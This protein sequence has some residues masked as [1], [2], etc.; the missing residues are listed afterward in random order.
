MA[1][2]NDEKDIYLMGFA[3]QAAT[4]SYCKRRQ[5]GAIIARDGRPV[6]TG[7][8]G[9][10]SGL[11]NECEDENGETSEFTVHAEQNAIA[12]CA[13]FG[14]ASQGTTMYITLSP[15]AACAKLIA[16]CGIVRV[17]YKERYKDASGIVYL[18]R[19]GV[20]VDFLN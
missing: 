18:L 7:M 8:N 14:I 20:V 6:A 17:V 11:P 2:T 9:T 1:K 13:K 3:E 19:C 5:V 15:C 10:V 16:S 12:Q 4:G